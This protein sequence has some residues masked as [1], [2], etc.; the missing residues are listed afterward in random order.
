MVVARQQSE[1][2]GRGDKGAKVAHL[3]KDD[4]AKRILVGD[5]QNKSSLVEQVRLLNHVGVGTSQILFASV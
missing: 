1:L 2:G 4:G 5:I 3:L